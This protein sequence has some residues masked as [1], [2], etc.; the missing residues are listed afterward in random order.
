M[1]ASA[2]IVAALVAALVLAI[3]LPSG[4]RSHPSAKAVQ[5]YENAILAPVKDWGSVEILGMR[6]S[7]KD[8]VGGGGPDT[9]PATA[10]I[11]E[12][13]AWQ[14]AFAHDRALIAAVRPPAGLGRCRG[15]FLR[16][17]DRYVEAAQGF[18]RA[19]AVPLAQRR[20]IVE[21]A[22]TAATEGDTLFDQASGVLQR[23]RLAAGLDISP[24]F[25]NPQTSTTR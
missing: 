6:P 17:L 7:V 16:A 12:S 23:A 2:G 9:L 1:I 24:N 14:A 13:R 8:L 25:P 10:V 5:R 18:G 21:T 20:P 3:V 19:A 22:I 4:G 11:T 15:L